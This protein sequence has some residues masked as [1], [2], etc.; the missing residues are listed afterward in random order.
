MTHLSFHVLPCQRPCRQTAPPLP[1]VT[2]QQHGMEYWW[3]GSTSTAVPPISTSDV[4]G[5][6]NNIEGITLRAAI[7]I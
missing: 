1:S 5:Q 3:K 6:H 2:Q 4:I 7:I